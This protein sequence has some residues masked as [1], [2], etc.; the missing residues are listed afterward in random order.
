MSNWFRTGSGTPERIKHADIP[1]YVKKAVIDVADKV[2]AVQTSES[3][4]FIA[5]SDAHQLDASAIPEVHY[6]VAF[7]VKGTGA[8]LTATITA[9]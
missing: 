9:L 3:I 2:K 7:C 8:N 5:M 6:C 1:D 4:T